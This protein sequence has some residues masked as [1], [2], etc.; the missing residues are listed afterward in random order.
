MVV[1]VEEEEEAE[2]AAVGVEVIE[3][4]QP[5]LQICK[6]LIRAGYIMSFFFCFLFL[7]ISACFI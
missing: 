2:A 3:G 7:V 1:V 5:G 4:Y 6:L